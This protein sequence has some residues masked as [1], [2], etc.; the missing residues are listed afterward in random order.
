[1]A[2][3]PRP[4]Q[5][6]ILFF[7]GT[8]D[9]V[10]DCTNVFRMA[11]AIEP[12]DH[13]TRQRFF[14]HPGVGTLPGTQLLGGATGIG[15]TEILLEGYEWLARR[16]EPGD[17]IWVFG[18]SRGAYTARSLAGLIRKCGLMRIVTP[19]AIEEAAALYRNH[20]VYPDSVA[21]DEFRRRYARPN[22]RIH[23]LG[24]WDTVGALGIPGNVVLS[25]P[26]LK[27]H[28]TELSSIVLRA[29]QAMA[30]DEHREEFDVSLWKGAKDNPQVKK[31]GQIDVEQ[32]W[33]VGSHGDVGGGCPQDTLSSIPLRWMQDKATTAGLVLRPLCTPRED[34]EM[35]EIYDSYTPFLGGTYSFLRSGLSGDRKRF[36]RR[37]DE[38]T[39]PAQGEGDEPIRAI[40]VTVDPSVYRRM[41]RDR[42]YR[43]ETL[44]GRH[45]IT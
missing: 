14:Y 45:R 17:E 22:V 12:Y 24:V 11:S 29:Y 37:F 34:A 25:R 3:S 38:V 44:E 41:E 30:L 2:D 35:A 4:G 13:S 23:F 16:Y 39:Q 1:M 40:N 9:D 6:L 8:W 10:R 7:D 18:F 19:G 27:W 15:L 5:R 43:P 26:F 28:D 20:D 33:F 32:R 36:S 42:T 21:G 31:A